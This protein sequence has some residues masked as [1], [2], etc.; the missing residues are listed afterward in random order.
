MTEISHLQG[1]FEREIHRDTQVYEQVIKI[2][3]IL[4]AR[5]HGDDPNNLLNEIAKVLG[6]PTLGVAGMSNDF[7]ISHIVNRKQGIV[8]GGSKTLLNT[9]HSSAD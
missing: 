5:G 3:K 6:L 9:K 7:K 1:R 2:I 8:I 4:K